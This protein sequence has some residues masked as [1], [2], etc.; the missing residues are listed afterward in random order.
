VIDECL[1]V[2]FAVTGDD[3][4]LAAA[5]AATGATVECAPPQLRRDDNVLLRFSAPA[6]DADA[7]AA[8]LD[9]DDRIRYLHAAGGDGRTDFR[10]LSKHP[11]VVHELT[12]AGFMTESVRYT[13]GTESYVGAVV[14]NDVLEG[15][16]AAAGETVGVTLQR[17]HQLRDDEGDPVAARWDL[18]PAQEAALRAA[19]DAGYFQVPRDATAGDVAAE[20]GIS[21]S[22]F[23]ERL[24]RGQAGLLAQLLD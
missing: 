12:D 1:Q 18:T 8:A 13:D 10:C 24:R 19:L 17:I 14:G 3:C 15:V 2:E 11:C 4:P 16:L 9:A 5:S 23:L 21:K 22:A 6:A 7:L 20:L